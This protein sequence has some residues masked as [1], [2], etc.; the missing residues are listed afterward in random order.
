MNPSG[1]TK[2]VFSLSIPV[3]TG[4]EY[5]ALTLESAALQDGLAELALLDASGGDARVTSL[6][7][8]YAPLIAFSY[9]RNADAGQSA[10]IQEGWDNTH[11][12]FVGWLNTDDYLLPGA[13]PRVKE[14]FD[15]D[16]G[17]DVVYGHAIYVNENGHF[18]RYFP[19]ISGDISS[20]CSS[21]IICQPACFVRRTAMARVAG[22]D[23][24]L[25]YTMD[26]DL[27]IRLYKAGCKFRMVEEP[28]AVVCDR[29]ESKTN[30]GG[31]TRY[32]E[33]ERC[34]AGN[35]DMT[36]RIRAKTIRFYEPLHRANPFGFFVVNASREILQRVS[37]GRK[38]TP[39]SSLFGLNR[40]TNLIEDRCRITMAWFGATPPS[41][42][43]MVVDRPGD[44]YICDGN[45]RRPWHFAETTRLRTFGFKGKCMRYTAQIAATQ[46]RRLD[47][48]IGVHGGPCRLLGFS[49]HWD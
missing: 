17:I 25:D 47:Y 20:I 49:L 24:S 39:P 13:L 45:Q 26:W 28:L 3:K 46:E 38:R 48:V 35:R 19:A 10:A 7:E 44:Y 40:Y 30:S 22:L 21:N 2:A 12:T 27:W 15:A 18:Q 23:P 6:V 43:S 5:L 29:D 37:R 11:G 1:P 41:R 34:L 14:V 33:I 8:K 31:R 16:P 42:A 36:A 4:I 9:H 32:R